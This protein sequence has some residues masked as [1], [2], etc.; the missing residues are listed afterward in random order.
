MIYKSPAERVYQVVIHLIIGAIMLSALFPLVYVIGMS[1]TS[2]PELIR[3]NYFVIVPE[4][5]TFAAYERILSSA[6]VWKSMLISVVRSTVGPLLT[7][8]MTVTGAFVLAR[9][10]LPGRNLLLFFVLATILFH[11]GLIP[12]YLVVKKLGLLD[13]IWALII[14]PLVDTFGLLVIKIFI[15]NLPDEIMDAARIDGAGELQM[16]TRIVVPLAAPALAAIGL[17][18]VVMH[19]NSW[20][21][22]LIYLTDK[23]LYPLQLVL[24]NMLTATS[25]T[26]DQMNF[27]LEDTQRVSSESVKMATVVVAMIPILCVYPFL[28]KHFAKGVYLGSTKG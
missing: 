9:K 23:E 28:Q 26:N 25:M 7:L 24:R 6:L 21:D 15:E 27:M 12:S 3:R 14:P 10:T 16:L 22:A 18:N 17:F 13:S 11:G 5:P 2:Q 19:W 20:F 4:Q 1:L 8:A